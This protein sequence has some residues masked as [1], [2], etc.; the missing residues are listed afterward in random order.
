MKSLYTITIEGY[1][2]KETIHFIG[3]EGHHR[4][5]GVV[6]QAKFDGEKILHTLD[7]MHAR[8]SK[9]RLEATAAELASAPREHGYCIDAATAE[10]FAEHFPNEKLPM[11]SCRHKTKH[12]HGNILV[13]KA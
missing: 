12:E 13:F 8:S 10:E 4:W 11:P 3:S 9:Q 1:G 7:R 6:D 2:Q 5:F